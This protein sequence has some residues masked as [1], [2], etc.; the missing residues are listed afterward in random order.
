MHKFQ[1]FEPILVASNDQIGKTVTPIRLHQPLK[2]TPSQRGIIEIMPSMK[3][4]YNCEKHVI[5]I[6]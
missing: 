4:G 2:A 1:F 6:I 3:S 5:N